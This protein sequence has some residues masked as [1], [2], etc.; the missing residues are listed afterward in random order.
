[1]SE[2]SIDW[3]KIDWETIDLVELRAATHEGMDPEWVEK[4]GV[5]SFAAALLCGGIIAPNETVDSIEAAKADQHRDDS[6][7]IEATVTH[8][9][10][11][12]SESN[13]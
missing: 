10:F 7:W 8:V 3:M 12:H 11:I 13:H 5:R 4:F 2:R 1:M 6:D 9:P